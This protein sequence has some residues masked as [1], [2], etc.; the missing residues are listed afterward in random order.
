MDDVTVS[1]GSEFNPMDEETFD[2]SHELYK[3]MRRECPVAHSTAFG[4]FWALFKFDDV[5]AVIEDSANVHHV[6]EE[7]RT[8]GDRG[9]RAGGCRSTS[10]RPSTRCSGGRSTWCSARAG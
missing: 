9:T 3:Q 6:G 8:A 5:V 1:A 2:N 4:G 10:T 7:R